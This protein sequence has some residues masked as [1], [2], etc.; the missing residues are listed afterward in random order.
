M[1]SR[2]RAFLVSLM[3]L[4]GSSACEENKRAEQVSSDPILQDKFE[5]TKRS[6][7]EIQANK[8]RNLNVYADCKTLE[9]L[10][11]NDLERLEGQAVKKLLSALEEACRD[12]KQF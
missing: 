10:F 9:M 5:T 11:H 12:A 7:E 1:L 6:L 4:L 3:L 8:K 2:R